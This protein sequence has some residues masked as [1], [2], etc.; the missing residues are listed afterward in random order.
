MG[1]HYSNVKV[2]WLGRPFKYRTFWTINRLFSVRFFDHHSN[3]GPFNNRTQI[4]HLNTRQVW[5]SDPHR[6]HFR[7]AL[8]TDI[9]LLLF[10]KIGR[11]LKWCHQYSGTGCDLLSNKLEKHT[12]FPRGELILILSSFSSKGHLLM[13]GSCPTTRSCLNP[14]E[15]FW[16]TSWNS[17]I[18]KI[19]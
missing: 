16:H 4:Y 9:N 12:W 15:T 7:Y 3:T 2:M 10:R 1:V 11:Q 19:W 6:S 17:Y 18:Q 5:Y 14:N 8:Q 13:T